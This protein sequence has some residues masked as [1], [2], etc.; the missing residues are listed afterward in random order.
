[1]KIRAARRDFAAM[2]GIREI[3]GETIVKSDFES[4]GSEGVDKLTYD[5]TLTVFVVDEAADVVFG[6]VTVP[7]TPAAGMLDCQH[8]VFHAGS[9]GE[10]RPLTAIQFVGFEKC[11]VFISVGPFAID[12]SS[13]V[14]VK[15]QAETKLQE[16]L[17]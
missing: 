17:L 2:S 3:T 10:I 11:R 6:M 14:K 4:A 15:E 9:M 12:I 16:I 5:V 8:G 1:M 13:H 7:E